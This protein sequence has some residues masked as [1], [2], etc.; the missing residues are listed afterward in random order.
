MPAH[1]DALPALMHFR[2]EASACVPLPANTKAAPCIAH[3][4]KGA[5]MS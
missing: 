2:P 3:P 4:E 1:S 5:A